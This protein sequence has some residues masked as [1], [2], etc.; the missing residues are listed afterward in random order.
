MDNSLLRSTPGV[1]SADASY[2]EFQ[3][4]SVAIPPGTKAPPRKMLRG[5]GV[6]LGWYLLA[7]ASGAAFLCGWLLGR[8]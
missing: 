6:A 1:V 8:T 2:Q 3:G 5:R 7:V 4:E